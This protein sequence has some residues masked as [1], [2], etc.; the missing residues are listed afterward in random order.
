ME[1]Q[2]HRPFDG[3]GNTLAHGYFPL[4]GRINFDDDEYFSPFGN[5]YWVVVVAEGK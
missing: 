5:P 4:D 2:C 3:P 1:V